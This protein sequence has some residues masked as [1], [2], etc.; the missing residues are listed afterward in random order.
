MFSP[1]PA[2]VAFAQKI[3]AAMP[4]GTYTGEASTDDDGTVL[5]QPVTVRVVL[6]APLVA[7]GSDWEAATRLRNAA[8]AAILAGARFVVSPVFNPSVIDLCHRYDVAVMPGCFTPTEILHAWE[9]GADLVKVFP[10]TALGPS[11][12]KDI[13]GPLP[14]VKLMPT[15]GVS[16]DNAGD[17]IA[18]GA[19]W[20]DDLQTL[21]ESLLPAGD[22][23]PAKGANHWAFQPVVRPIQPAACSCAAT[24]RPSERRWRCC[25]GSL[26]VCR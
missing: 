8:R 7:Q 4:D 10:A 17:W 20:P 19:R 18:A 16:I 2:E 22:V 25:R 3:L 5:D 14:Q 12:F 9:D 24:G 15:G 21:P 11:Y 13:R 6:G 23:A 1:D 26:P